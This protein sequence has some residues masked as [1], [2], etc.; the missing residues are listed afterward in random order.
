MIYLGYLGFQEKDM[1]HGPLFCKWFQVLGA[2]KNSKLWTIT[3]VPH[4]ASEDI[5]GT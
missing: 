1:K 4:D 5:E 3:W 2:Y